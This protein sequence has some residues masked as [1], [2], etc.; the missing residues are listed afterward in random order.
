MRLI[1]NFIVLLHK[2]F[3]YLSELFL[4]FFYKKCLASC[5]KNVT[6]KPSSSQFRGL[7]NMFFGDDVNIP[8]GSTFFSTKAKL[9]IGN[10]VIFGPCP[11]II[12]GNHRIDL[13]GK[14]I[15]DVDGKLPENDEDVVIEDDVWVGAN[16]T[17]LKGVTIGRGAVIGAC[18]L[19]CKDVMPYSIIGGIPAK[20]LKW[21]FTIDQIIN[22]ETNLYPAEKRYSR[23]QL[24]E[25]FGNEGIFESS[26]NNHYTGEPKNKP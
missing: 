1:A 7:E 8:V 14:Y 21:R 19:V 17:I 6:I 16:V 9:K 22:H 23:K 12:T 2:S 15:F 25:W 13:I 11:T 18:S 20:A 10:K 5:G 26:G 24:I 4:S 3:R